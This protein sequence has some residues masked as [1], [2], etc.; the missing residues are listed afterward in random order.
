MGASLY[1]AVGLALVYLLGA[2]TPAF[3]LSDDWVVE[4]ISR[5]IHL[6][7]PHGVDN[8]L[9][10]KVTRK[11]AAAT[12]FVVPTAS[13]ERSGRFARIMCTINSD[14]AKDVQTEKTPKGFNI[15]VPVPS[16]F[17]SGMINCQM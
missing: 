3:S 7:T 4:A 9:Q 6:S 11:N 2:A 14:A 1:A 5:K 17:T 8:L 10:Y 15:K 12:H 13:E 16:T